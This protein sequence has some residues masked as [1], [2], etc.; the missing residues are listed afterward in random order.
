MKMAEI[1]EKAVRQEMKLK[2]RKV[3]GG[4]GDNAGER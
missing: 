3:R 2:R 4:G 1:K